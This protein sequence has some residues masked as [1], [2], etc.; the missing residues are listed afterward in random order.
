MT[1]LSRAEFV[2]GALAVAT[3]ASTYGAIGRRVPAQ[4]DWERLGRSLQGAVVRP[5]DARFLAL[6]QPQNLRYAVSDVP[7]GI[8]LCRSARDVST[9]VRWAREHALPLVA[10]NGGHSYAGYS[11]TTGLMIDL[12]PM[13]QVS[14]DRASGVLVAGGGA[15]NR[16]AFAAGERHGVAFTHGRCFEV[17]IA[18]LTLGGGVGFD[19][20][21]H[22]LTC[23]H[24]VATQIVTA[25]GAIHERS[26]ANDPD[27]LFWACRGGGG[28]NFG[29]NTAMT[30]SAFPV[31]Q[32]TVFRIV[33]N[34]AKPERLLEALAAALERAPVTV[35]SKVAIV[36]PQRNG[37][38]IEIELL[39]QMAAPSRELLAILA[40]VLAAA[41]PATRSVFEM[42]YW[43]AERWLSEPGGAMYYNERS[44]FFNQPF[45]H[46]AIA[47]VLDFLRGCPAA[48]AQHAGT[49]AQFKLFQTG[50]RIN[51]VA[52][53]ETSFVHRSSTWLSS[54]E[55]HWQSTTPAKSARA[56]LDWQSSFYAA[57]VPLARG[58]AYQNF[59]DPDLR[60]WRAAYYG[61]NLPRLRKIKST[62]DPDGIFTFPE[63][64]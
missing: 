63:A 6:A 12:S 24:L 64:I 47:T 60:D 21:M 32:M 50:G 15:R 28:G 1:R 2:Q 49:E 39:G 62:V 45:D 42:P 26:A 40:P 37:A 57:I 58:G 16:H 5:G 55:V 35:G 4:R 52:S 54:I 11:R 19:M 23:D 30:F 10:R 36:A 53:H 17:G 44:R 56:L 22:Q 59:I 27:G 7:A 33:W 51:E 8:A 38:P 25:D 3:A 29:I 46:R 14:F 9:A 34:I 43:P 20:R 13:S 18:G 61:E 41:Q 31:S 48:T